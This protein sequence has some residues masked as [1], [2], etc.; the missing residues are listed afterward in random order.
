MSNTHTDMAF[1]AKFH[2]PYINK[3]ES[4]VD[5]KC[6][7]NF[8]LQVKYT[9]AMWDVKYIIR[10]WQVVVLLG[11]FRT[12]PFFGDTSSPCGYKIVCKSDH[13]FIEV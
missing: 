9:L 1:F 2:K 8:D 11:A 7:V 5:V 3:W 13:I 4:Q 10:T 12:M 6:Q